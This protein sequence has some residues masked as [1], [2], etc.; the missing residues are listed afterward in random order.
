MLLPTTDEHLISSEFCLKGNAQKY[1]LCSYFLSQNCGTLLEV[2]TTAD[3]LCTSM[4]SC[5]KMGEDGT[6][7][8]FK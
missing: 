6:L 3:G 8:F 1:K 5:A 7:C 4:Q 2:C